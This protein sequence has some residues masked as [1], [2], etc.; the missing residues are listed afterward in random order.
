MV[1]WE[2][3]VGGIDWVTKLTDEDKATQLSSRGY[4]NRYTAKAG[5]VLPM[6]SKGIPEHSDMTIIGDDYVMPAPAGWKSNIIIHQDKIDA[7]PLEVW[8]Q[9]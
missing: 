5:D 6:L 4:P 7:C 3:S 2:A 9:S 1:N 8:D